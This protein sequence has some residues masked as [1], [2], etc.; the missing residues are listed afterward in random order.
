MQAPSHNHVPWQTGGHRIGEAPAD[1]RTHRRGASITASVL[2]ATRCD[3]RTNASDQDRDSTNRNP[4][5]RGARGGDGLPTS[6]RRGRR[7]RRGRC[8]NDRSRGGGGRRARRG[9][10]RLAD[11]RVRDLRGRAVRQRGAVLLGCQVTLS[12]VVTLKD[13]YAAILLGTHGGV[14]SDRVSNLIELSVEFL[15]V[16]SSL[17]SEI[18]AR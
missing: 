4:R 17:S 14:S 2:G 18:D 8:R 11:R 10:G 16:H 1:E 9:S 7:L 13:G 5:G 3:E 15:E 6:L 12:L